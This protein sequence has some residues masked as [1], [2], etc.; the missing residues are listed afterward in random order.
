MLIISSTNREK[1]QEA[2]NKHFYSSTYRIAE[3]NT[4]TW[5][6]GEVKNDLKVVVKKG[7]F[8]IHQQNGN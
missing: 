7:R 4:I 2:L 3:D 6:N 8:Q 1:A 5:K